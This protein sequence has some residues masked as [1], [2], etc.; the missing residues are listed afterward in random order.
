M[1]FGAPSAGPDADVLYCSSVRLPPANGMP[2]DSGAP[3]GSHARGAERRPK[4]HLNA[5]APAAR[6]GGQDA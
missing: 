1:P 5:T 2:P 3:E 6:T 4:A